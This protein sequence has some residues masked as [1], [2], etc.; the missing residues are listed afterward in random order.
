MAVPFNQLE[1]QGVLYKPFYR[2]NGDK[3]F[4]Q[5]DDGHVYR[6]KQGV[7]RCAYS[8]YAMNANGVFI[9][10]LQNCKKRPGAR[11]PC[12]H[13]VTQEMDSL[14]TLWRITKVSLCRLRMFEHIAN[15]NKDTVKRVFDHFKAGLYPDLVVDFDILYG[16]HEASIKYL[17]RQTLKPWNSADTCDQEMRKLMVDVP[18]YSGLHD[19]YQLMLGN[20]MAEQA[21]VNPNPAVPMEEGEE[22]VGARAAVQ[23]VVSARRQGV[24][25][26]IYYESTLESGQVVRRRL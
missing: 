19:E 8:Q 3:S 14:I 10:D 4:Y 26:R 6:I 11:R 7:L 22:V 5:S 21:I 13:V 16:K 1:Y 23:E 12:H 25:G 18:R 24:V 20:E 17:R 2:M 9:K 15:F